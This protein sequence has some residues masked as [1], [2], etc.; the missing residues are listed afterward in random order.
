MTDNQPVIEIRAM[1]IADYDAVLSLWKV[2]EGVGLSK[3]DERGA[4][5]RYLD[6]N[7][8]MSFV[9]LD[10]QK[11]VGAVL[12]GHDGRRGLLHH[13]AVSPS[14]RRLGI[15]RSLV[16]RCLLAL[17]AEGID[18]THLFVFQTNSSGREFWRQI[19]WYE[20][21]ELVLMSRDV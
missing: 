11:V 6:R 9:A 3:A 1:R 13:L 2:T 8:G 7:P 16:D 4:I 17:K 21:P 19:G 20:R 5:E 10:G 18:K 12:A 14:Y 15:G